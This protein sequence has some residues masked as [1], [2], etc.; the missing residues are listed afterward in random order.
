[1]RRFTGRALAPQA[2]RPVDGS[3]NKSTGR[4]RIAN[5]VTRGRQTFTVSMV[6]PGDRPRRSGRSAAQKRFPVG[7]AGKVSVNS[8]IG[9]PCPGHHLQFV[10]RRGRCL[11]V[12]ASNAAASRPAIMAR[13]VGQ[14]WSLPFSLQRD[15]G[16][17]RFS[18]PAAASKANYTTGS[19]AMTAA[20]EIEW[21]RS[22]VRRPIASAP[23]RTRRRSLDGFQ[24]RRRVKIHNR[25]N[26]RWKPWLQ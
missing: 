19:V 6:G 21:W 22:R 8:V 10:G 3:L 7:S 13:P 9:T 15:E 4:W 1:M 17:V 18:G 20:S 5:T 25:L 12:G 11:R 23:Q 16:R 24:L 14:E 2:L 26:D